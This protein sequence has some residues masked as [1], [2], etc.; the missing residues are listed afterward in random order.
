MRKSVE[1]KQQREVEEQQ[2]AVWPLLFPFQRRAVHRYVC[3][4]GCTVYRK[5][6]EEQ[7][8]HLYCF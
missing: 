6:K 3:R 2:C 8:A 7:A 4:E 1:E 5:L